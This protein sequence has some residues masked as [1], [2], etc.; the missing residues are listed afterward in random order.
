LEIKIEHLLDL[1]PAARAESCW[2]AAASMLY[3]G[4]RPLAAAYARESGRQ[5][6]EDSAAVLH[7]G[8][9]TLPQFALQ[10]ELTVLRPRPW[11]LDALTDLLSRRP[12]W[13]GAYRPNGHAMVVTGMLGNGT[14]GGTFITVLD[15][16]PPDTGKVHNLQF[17]VWQT[18]FSLPSMYILHRPLP[19]PPDP[20]AGLK[21]LI[22]NDWND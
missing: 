12:L 3:G 17:S 13:A 2:A 7:T 9:A 14:P 11:T 8:P 1:V 19:P 15:P 21:S 16:L 18:R 20:L 6:G 4:G 22:G 5:T 10:W